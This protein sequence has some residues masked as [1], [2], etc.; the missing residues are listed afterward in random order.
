MVLQPNQKHRVIKAGLALQLKIGNGPLNP[1]TLE[2]CEHVMQQNDIDFAPLAAEYL[3]LLEIGIEEA[4]AKKIP[5]EKALSAL[6]VPVMQLKANAA[7]F[8]YPLIGSLANI[9]L[10]FLESIEVIDEDALNIVQAH[11]T[12]LKAIVSKK[13]SG[14]GGASGI[15]MQEELQ[16][17]CARYMSRRAPA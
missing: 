10:S 15:A 6:T 3:K 9:M 17:A 5:K 12:T 14:A 2:R 11:H 13:M 1:D 4:R 7:T 8:H 16:K